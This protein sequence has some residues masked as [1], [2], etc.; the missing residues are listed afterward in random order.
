LGNILKFI[1]KFSHAALLGKFYVA[2]FR[3]SSVKFGAA[4]ELSRRIFIA[5]KI[6]ILKFTASLAK[7]Q[8]FAGS[9][10]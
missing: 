1:A 2:K 8:W 3:F 7:T 9:K 5:W 10:I 6:C 4:D